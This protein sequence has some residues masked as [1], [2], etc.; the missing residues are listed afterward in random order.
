R[1]KHVSDMLAESTIRRQDYSYQAE[2]SGIGVSSREQARRLMTPDEILAMP[3]GQALV[4]VRGLRPMKVTML[5]YGRVSPWREEVGDNPLEGGRLRGD[6]AFG[7]QYAE[8]TAPV[9]EGVRYRTH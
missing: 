3:R 1:A 6:P 8:S 5:D 2:A 7:I 4:F 9:I